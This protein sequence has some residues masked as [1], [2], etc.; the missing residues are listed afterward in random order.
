MLEV[1]N[2]CTMNYPRVLVISNNS[3]SNTDS[4]GRTLGN[5][6]AG[7]PKER[8]AQF[9]IST[10]GPNF[11]LC[12]N[13][14]C[15]TDREVLD[16]SLHLR[17]A[18]GRKLIPENHTRT[19]GSRGE[20]KK[21][22]LMMLARNVIWGRNRWRSKGF[23]EWISDFK[24]EAILLF[25]SDSAFMLHIGTTLSKELG[26]PLMMYNTE[27]Y[28]FFKSNYCRTK[29]KWDWL[30]FPI[31]QGLYRKQV[32]KTMKMVVFSMYLN[33]LLQADYDREFGGPSAV[34]YTSSA[35][36]FEEHPFNS[37]HP[38]FSYIGNLTFNR[39]KALME[40]ADVLQSINKSFVLNIYGKPLN[41][42]TEEEL[43]SHP[44]ISFKGFIPYEEVLRVIHNS[45]V[46]FHAET[47]DERWEESLRYGFSTKIADS[48]SSGTC[49]V[50]YA[51]A[52]IACS[53]YIQSTKSGWFADTKDGLRRCLEEILYDE[54][55]RKAVQENAKRTA[56][57]NHSQSKNSQVF[58]QI[59][60]DNV[61]KKSNA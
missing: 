47:S 20:G 60:C 37:E 21:T 61:N 15:L 35:L 16:A 29:T 12:D 33:Q 52:H 40:V 17:K 4:N 5:L 19:T 43:R 26:V 1:V 55:K 11:D 59:I 58:Q 9:C 39:P 10:D 53:Q 49:F 13:Y 51:P 31:Y 38:A 6:F 44:G 54:G 32:R 22:L 30:L 48:V 42:E 8:L 41:K 14:Y 46:L 27:G 23:E 36:Q 7:W 57:T 45:D 24:P 25:F 28:F 34:L 3:F 18:E 2:C 50:L 56:E